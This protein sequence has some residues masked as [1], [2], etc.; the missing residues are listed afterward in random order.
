MSR[1]QTTHNMESMDAIDQS[2]LPSLVW[3]ER[4]DHPPPPSR[5]QPSGD[6]LCRLDRQ[7]D[8]LI[9]LVFGSM[10]LF[11]SDSMQGC[12]VLAMV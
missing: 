1:K 6:I 5:A 11:S 2:I 3:M 12:L 4:M 10:E 7:P 8:S 9:S